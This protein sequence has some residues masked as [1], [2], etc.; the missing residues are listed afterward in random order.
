M[1]HNGKKVSIKKVG[2]ITK[3]TIRERLDYLKSFVD[4]L[5]KHDVELIFDKYSGPLM[6]AKNYYEKSKLLRRVDLAIILGG[7]GTLLKTARNVSRKSPLIAGVN[8]G[9]VGFLTGFTAES[10]MKNIGKVLAGDFCYDERILLRATIYRN[11]KKRFTSLALND[12]VINQGGFARL[13][14]LKVE[15]NG[16]QM[17]DYKADGLIVATPTGSTGHSLSAGGPIVHPKI[18]GI[19]LTPLCP[20]KLGMRPIIIPSDRQ[21]QILLETEWRAEKKPVVLTIDGQLTVNLK[22]GDSIRIRKSQRRFTMIRMQ[23]HNYYKMLQK[24]LNWGS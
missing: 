18:D 8:L 24:K 21:I 11:G 12:A 2:I 7:D 20:V 22:K 16:R 10:I 1:A 19:V 13:I 17:A 4:E 14:N 6:K 23:G 5:Q 3:H 15:M 9:N